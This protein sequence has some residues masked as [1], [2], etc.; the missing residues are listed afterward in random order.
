MR[1]ADGLA[2]VH[3]S[4]FVRLATITT[5]MAVTILLIII[6]FFA[7]TIDPPFSSPTLNE[8]LR[9]AH[10][11]LVGPVLLLITAVVL[12]AHAMLRRLLLPLRGLADGV[13]RLTRGELDVVVP[14]ATRDEFGALTQAFNRMVAQVRGM[15]GARDQLLLDVSHELRSPVTRLKVALELL[16]EDA[17]RARLAADVREMEAMITELLE[18]ER[19][20]DGRAIRKAPVDLRRLVDDVVASFDDRRPTLSVRLPAIPVMLH[21]D[22]R[23]MTV[24]I[25]NLVENAVTY[26]LPDSG[27]I[28]IVIT[29]N[30]AE[31]T[32]RVTDDGPGIPESEMANVFEP[33]YRLDRSRSRRTGGYGLGLSICKRIVEAHGGSIVIERGAGRGASFVV[34]LPRPPA[35]Q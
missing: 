33:F 15:I 31:V 8:R 12:I 16:P 28:D 35:I 21:A 22:P 34:K 25:R 23:M 24:V 9:A 4:V 18:L 26:S 7:L 17:L 5:M 14:S 1:E 13:M 2:R 11:A 10:F 30:S 6:V 32:L 27:P 3:Q 29:D 20:R 19:L